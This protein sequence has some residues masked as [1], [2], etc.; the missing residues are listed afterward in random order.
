MILSE[1]GLNAAREV[2]RHRGKLAPEEP[3]MYSV[4]EAYLEGAGFTE[5][6]ELTEPAEG[7]KAAP[8]PTGR[9]RL[10][11]EWHDE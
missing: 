5:E 1:E 9:V 4:I 7:S 10:V 8:K 3:N 11:G 6:Q 2:D